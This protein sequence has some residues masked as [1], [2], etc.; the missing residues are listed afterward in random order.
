MPGV[1]IGDN[2]VVAAGVVVTKPVPDGWI[3]GGSPART[4]KQTDEY[5]KKAKQNSLHIGHLK[6]KE[7]IKAY[8]KIFN[9]R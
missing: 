1:N 3:V 8:Q 4:I 2:C 7:K 5:I 6:G 9:V